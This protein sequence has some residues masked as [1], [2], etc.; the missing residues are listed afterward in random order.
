MRVECN[1]CPRP[2]RRAAFGQPSELATWVGTTTSIEYLPMILI[3]K[4]LIAFGTGL[5]MLALL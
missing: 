3:I 2:A 5:V 4:V 1:Q